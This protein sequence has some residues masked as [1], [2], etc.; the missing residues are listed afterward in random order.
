MKITQN[1]VY[2]ICVID[3]AGNTTLREELNVQNIDNVDMACQFEIIGNKGNKVDGNQWY[4]PN[5]TYPK[6]TLKLKSLAMGPSGVKLG[7]STENKEKYTSNYINTLENAFVTTKID[8]NKN[9]VTYYGFVRSQSGKNKSCPITLYYEHTMKAASLSTTI[10]SDYDKITI[11]YTKAEADSGIASETCYLY[12]SSDNAEVKS[13]V[14][15]SGKCTFTGLKNATVN[16]TYYV[17]IKS[18]S[19]AGNEKWSSQSST[20]TI[21]GY[22]T[23]G[24]VNYKD[25]TICTNVCGGGTYN[26]IAYSKMDNTTVCSG[27]NL[28]S[29]GSA[30]GSVYYVDGPICS[31]DC[32]GTY[33]QIAYSDIND[34]RCPSYDKSSGGGS[35]GGIKYSHSSPCNAICP[36]ACGNDASTQKGTKTD[37]YISSINSAKT[38]DPVPN[39]ACYISCDATAPCCEKVLDSTWSLYDYGN[40]CPGVP[41]P[42]GSYTAIE[43]SSTGFDPKTIDLKGYKKIKITYRVKAVENLYK[44]SLEGAIFVTDN[45]NAKAFEEQYTVKQTFV[46]FGN[47]ELTAGQTGNWKTETITLNS[48][49]KKNGMYLHM[50]LLGRS[51]GCNGSLISDGHRIISIKSIE[52]CK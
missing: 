37:Y 50:T 30:C 35:C 29:G 18:I 14:A 7:I 5:S 6:L 25:G 1:G 27:Q 44:V 17:K 45:N 26:R 52:L 48:A 51:S 4:I 19:K 39:V 10:S 40:V 47:L 2:N 41:L 46:S 31:D 21:P 42:N 23:S 33:N 24:H 9:G 13:V 15:S 16:N 8:S 12:N 22:C 28:P 38:C 32:G 20:V 11:T 36:T 49:V 43:P 3:N 34:D